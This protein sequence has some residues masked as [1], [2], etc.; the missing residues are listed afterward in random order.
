MENTH[1]TPPLVE[2]RV[3]S[4]VI[5]KPHDF[6]SQDHKFCIFA[7]A[8]VT[9][10]NAELGILSTPLMRVRCTMRTYRTTDQANG[11]NYH[12][13]PVSARTPRLG[14]ENSPPVALDIWLRTFRRKPDNFY[15]WLYLQ[16]VN[17]NDWL[18]L[19][20]AVR[21]RNLQTQY[22]TYDLPSKY[23]PTAQEPKRM[24]SCVTLWFDHP[25]VIV[26]GISWIGPVD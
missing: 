23:L 18:R 17:N 14:A 8:A 13:P 22:S 3:T 7:A 4:P 1:A 24:M 16:V 6:A 10:D 15:C 26:E 2:S 20:I 9:T 25:D 12:K 19:L 5:S 21:M 11:S